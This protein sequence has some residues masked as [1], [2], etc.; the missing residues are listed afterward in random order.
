MA[1][2]AT[3]D[4]IRTILDLLRRQARDGE[5]G[6]V[7]FFKGPTDRDGIA[8]LTRTEADLYIDSLRGEY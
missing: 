4:Q 8:T 7:G 5:A 6:T 1:E 3:P 2:T